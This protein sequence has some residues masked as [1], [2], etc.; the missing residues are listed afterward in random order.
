MMRVDLTFEKFLPF[1]AGAF[2]SLFSSCLAKT[3]LLILIS[4]SSVIPRMSSSQSGDLTLVIFDAPLYLGCEINH[5]KKRQKVQQPAS[6]VLAMQN[7]KK[8]TNLP[9]K[10]RQEKNNSHVQQWQNFVPAYTKNSE[11][12]ADSRSRPNIYTI[13]N[14]TMISLLTDSAANERALYSKP[15]NSLPAG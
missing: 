15:K 7:K 4:Y 13:K 14:E 9:Y 1:V 2:L 11:S 8:N 6:R 12:K 5:S 10:N 3:F